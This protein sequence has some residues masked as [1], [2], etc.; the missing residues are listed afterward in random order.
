[1]SGFRP[2][3]IGG[4]P[5]GG[6]TQDKKPLML[7]DEAYSDLENAY[8]WRDRT[9]KRDGEVPIGRLTRVFSNQAIGNSS[10]S[11]WTFNLYT[12]L[13]I[14]PEPNAEIAEGSVRITI[15]TLANPFID[16]GDGTL[17]NATG[18]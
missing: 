2:I 6:L 9:K 1:M 10:A 12:K 16:Q 11:P 18:G 8:V 3:L 14:T 17:S 5:S 7:P 15:A 4:Y 13:G